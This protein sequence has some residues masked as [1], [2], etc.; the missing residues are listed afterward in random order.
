MK[1]M[2]AILAF[3]LAAGILFTGCSGGGSSSTSASGVSLSMPSNISPVPTN[4]TGVASSHMAKHVSLGSLFAGVAATDPGTDYSD[5]TT[6]K[7]V[8]EHVLSQF[9]IINTILDAMSQTHFSESGN[10]GIGPYKSMIAWKE[11]NGGGGPQGG[12]QQKKL[13]PWIVDSSLIVE[14]G[15]SVNQ[16][17]AWIEDEQDGT[18]VVIRVK[19]KIYDS[20]TVKTDGSYQD[21]GVWTLNAVFNNNPSRYFSASASVGSSG[22]A[23]V[24]FHDNT[25]PPEE[26]KAIL[27]TSN[28]SGYGE[29]SYPDYSTCQS[30]N[31]TPA[32]VDAKYSYDG[33]TVGV[34]TTDGTNTTGPSFKNRAST[35]DVTMYYGLY[36]SVT[37][38]DV[39]KTKNF[40][41]PL[42]YTVNGVD[43]YVYYG[44]WQ[45][46]HSLWANGG[47]VPLNTPL[48]RMDLGPNQTETYTV[49]TA[50]NFS[51]SLTKRTLVASNISNILNLPVNT[52][53]NMST[54]MIY[55]GTT[56]CNA[57]P[58]TSNCSSIA[59]LSA[60][61]ADSNNPNQ[62]ISLYGTLGLT[63]GNF[64]YLSSGPNGAGF[65]GATQ[66]N[67]RWTSNGN[68]ATPS[69]NDQLW[70][71]VG[72]TI[73]IEYTDKA[74][75]YSTGNPGWVKKKLT[76]FDQQTW[77]P[78]FDDSLD[79]AYTL[80]SGQQY[81]L[82][83]QGT[84][85]VLTTGVNATFQIEV[86]TVANPINAMSFTG[87]GTVFT[88]QWSN[89][90]GTNYTFVTDSSDPRFLNLVYNTV[91]GNDP[92]LSGVLPG[93][94][95]DTGIYGL[96]ANDGTQYNWDYAT[97]QNPYGL[98]TY[99]VDSIS[100]YKLLDD[101]ISIKSFT[102][103]NSSGSITVS[104][105]YSGWMSG[106]PDIYSS[107][108]LTNWVMTSDL[109]TKVYNIPDGTLVDDA[110]DSSKHYLI[111]P[112]QISEF[113]NP[114]SSY[115]G[116]L[117]PSAVV[118]DLSTVPTLD[119]TGIIP[120]MATKPNITLIKYSEGNLVQ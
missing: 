59:D 9:Q 4:A 67:G 58:G 89:G 118:A 28:G 76:A 41:F 70:V 119:S 19:V 30:Q 109:Q 78:T 79:T 61:E 10:L 43:S 6:H 57:V 85:F 47:S 26:V 98:L 96:I 84:N 52:W 62:S 18:P 83:N 25:H 75:V 39:L 35:T 60:L 74:P 95:V 32:T 11:D 104:P 42:K 31:C 5:A 88:P 91:D 14:N 46:R 81:Y 12:G 8:E 111:K 20:P 15:H 40:G 66:S 117:D 49:T 101:P 93:D 34:I 120:G 51:G 92:S 1:K 113:L 116:S 17:L 110:T 65:Y 69:T 68:I 108:R 36:D 105:M 106:L 3:T 112:L 45:G 38:A 64:V 115:S 94:I 24:K 103:T 56:W 53:T 7:H 107:L 114:I 54:T 22:E 33:T 55:T 82:M 23:I 63:S 90:Y 73:Y 50:S 87:S 77:T 99:L 48:T 80:A 16:V 71:N 2:T 97:S 102:V 44:S 21:Y 27:N 13:Q 100:Q 72:G 37:G 29:I 86:Q